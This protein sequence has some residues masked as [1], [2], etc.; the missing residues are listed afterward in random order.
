MENRENDMFLHD[1]IKN[2]FSD[3]YNSFY[4]RWRLR[5]KRKRT[6]EE[7]QAIIEDGNKI[8]GKYNTS[9]VR[10]MVEDIMSIW[11]KQDKDFGG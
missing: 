8:C 6:D 2:S 5:E 3:V 1:N 4:C 9:L 7:W 10:N 11:E